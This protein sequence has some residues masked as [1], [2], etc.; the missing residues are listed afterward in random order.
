M[1]DLSPFQ[2]SVGCGQG[3]RWHQSNGKETDSRVDKEPYYQ[4]AK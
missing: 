4:I 3:I 1:A 2:D